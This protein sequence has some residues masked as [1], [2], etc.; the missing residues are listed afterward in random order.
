MVGSLLWDGGTVFAATSQMAHLAQRAAWLHPDDAA[1]L[2]IA[3]GDAI[4][5]RSR[6]GAI[7]TTAHLDPSIKPGSIF[8]PYSFPTAAVG[9]LFDDYV[10][11][12]SVAVKKSEV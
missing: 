4:E 10:P 3:E 8:V 6:S 11:R 7:H 1:R 9:N 12:T 5:I 2:A